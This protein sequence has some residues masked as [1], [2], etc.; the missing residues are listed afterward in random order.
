MSKNNSKARREKRRNEAIVRT[1]R[2][3]GS[4]IDCETCSGRHHKDFA[5]REVAA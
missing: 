2:N 3:A 1:E 4:V 5:C